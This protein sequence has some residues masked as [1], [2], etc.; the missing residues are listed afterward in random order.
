MEGFT[1]PELKNAI[2]HGLLN[3]TQLTDHAHAIPQI[4]QAFS[5]PI[6]TAATTTSTTRRLLDNNRDMLDNDGF[7]T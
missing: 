2:L 3:A 6:T 7:P 5:L 1:T 4:L